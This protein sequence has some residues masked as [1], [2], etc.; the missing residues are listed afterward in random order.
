MQIYPVGFVPE[1]PDTCFIESLKGSIPEGLLTKIKRDVRSEFVS[2]PCVRK[3][4][5]N[6]GIRIEVKLEQSDKETNGSATLRLNMW[7]KCA[8]L[9]STS[10]NT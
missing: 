10:T 7:L 1:S 2:L 4:A 6:N 9:V 8:R 5:Q 3:V